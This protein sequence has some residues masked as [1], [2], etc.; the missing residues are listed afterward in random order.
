MASSQE[1]TYLKDNY[2]VAYLVGPEPVPLSYEPDKEG[3]SE[4]EPEKE[5]PGPGGD[6]DEM[7]M[8]LKFQSLSSAEG[9]RQLEISFSESGFIRRVTGTSINKELTLD[10]TDVRIDQNIPDAKFEYKAPANANVFSDFLFEVI[11]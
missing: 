10:F 6:S 2:S 5:V 3:E 7:V 8:K 11:D 4:E 1:L 9:F